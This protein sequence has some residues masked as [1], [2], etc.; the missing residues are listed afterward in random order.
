MYCNKCGEHLPENSKFC[1]KCGEQ[2]YKICPNCQKQISVYDDF[3]I[4]CGQ[5]QEQLPNR[6]EVPSTNP[7]IPV[8]K[9]ATQK[10]Y[11]EKV[12]TFDDLPPHA[13]DF[14]RELGGFFLKYNGTYGII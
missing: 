14:S 1:F 3:C 13:R 8:K 5:K 9:Q 7:E 6:P 4:H 10:Q 2:Q 11:E 12:F